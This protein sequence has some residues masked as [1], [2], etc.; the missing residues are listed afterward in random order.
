M[1][2]RIIACGVIMGLL[3]S[4][5]M[6]LVKEGRPAS[7]IVVAE[8]AP[9]GTLLAARD[10]Q[11]HLEKMSGAKISIVTPDKIQAK[12]LICVGESDETRKVGYR[13]PNFKQSGYDIQVKEN[14]AILTGPVTVFRKKQTPY[15]ND[16]HEQMRIHSL[17]SDGVSAEEDCGPMHAVSAFLEHLGVRFYAPYEDG[18]IIPHLETVVVE[19]FSETKTAAFARRVYS[20]TMP[21]QDLE[22]A[23]WFRRL[24]CGSSLECAGMF[25]IAAVLKGKVH[26]EWAAADQ[27]GQPMLSNEGCIFPRFTNKDFQRRCAEYVCRFLDANPDMKEL[28]LVLPS[29]RGVQDD[30]DF[31]AWL[32]KKVF[33][34]P[35]NEDI[36]AAFYI[37][38]ANEVRK[39][40]PDCVLICRNDF[41]S[42]HY[43]SDIPE[44]LKFYPSSMSVVLYAWQKNREKYLKQL[45][46]RADWFSKHPMQQ[47]EWWNEFECPDTPRQGFWFMHALQEVR[48]GQQQYLSGIVIETG[49]DKEAK[50]LAEVPLIHLM[51]YVNSKLLWN[52]DLDMDALLDEYCRLWFGTAEKEMRTFLTFAENMAS[53]QQEM[54]SIFCQNEQ[55]WENDINFW[56]ELLSKAKGKT[57][58]GS[59]YRRRIEALEKAFA[60]LKDVFPKSAPAGNSLVGKI[61]PSKTFCDG[62]FSKYGNW[63]VLHG[64]K[65]GNR[66]EFALGMTEDRSRL[67]VAFRCYEPEMTKLKKAELLPDDPAIFDFEH[68]RIDFKPE[69]RIGYMAAINPWGSFA[70]GSHD[71]DELAKWG[72]FM[73]WSKPMTRG[74]ARCYDNRWE[75][76]IVIDVWDCGKK[77]DFGEPWEID[78]TRSHGGRQR[79]Q[80]VLGHKY[81]YQLTL[82]KVDSIGRPLNSYY[83]RLEQIHGTRDEAVYS[84]KRAEGKVD[85]S[86]AWDSKEWKDVPEMRLGWELVTSASS[87]FHPDARAKIQ[88]DD[89]YLYVLYQVRDQYVR[90]TFKNDQDMV[91]LDSCM[92]FF[93]QP[94]RAGPYYNFECNCIGTLLLYEAKRQGRRLGMV[95]VS[96]EELGEV[97]RFSTLPRNLSGELEMPV[98]WRLGLQIPLSLFIRRCGVKL[99]LKGQVWYGN[100]YKCADWTSHPCWLM[101]KKNETFHYPEGFGAFVFE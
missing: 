2:W 34:Q 86:S 17:Q 43:R 67:F 64:D 41:P 15:E 38:V 71:P 59:I 8:N 74:W 82:P 40:H 84:V 35:V 7:E 10:L 12:N 26:S 42:S 11:F 91:C 56:F 87:G 55:Q 33:P 45:K 49:T 78:I 28:E 62:D 53:L 4:F 47:R 94:D 80:S 76:E 50:R 73:G 68:I 77:P 24:K 21:G 37:A 36:M 58:A 96:L 39:R 72:S 1:S 52:P 54:R 32:T 57:S 70:D 90:G 95:P 27:F 19:D 66:T 30:R 5:G 16:L 44:N 88:Y 61:L 29:L 31:K 75:A 48:K 98:T 23:M 3:S 97:K 22:C 13:M 25:P 85:I 83:E 14:V 92:E 89:E 69:G 9:E 6:E 81:Q 46:K 51:Y 93:I 100:V 65:E 79:K 20:G 99:P 60:Q 18:T 63:T 101:W